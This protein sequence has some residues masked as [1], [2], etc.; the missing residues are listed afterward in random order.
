[1][2]T[3]QATGI[4]SITNIDHKDSLYSVKV[5]VGNPPQF[6]DL[7]IDTGH[8]DWWIYSKG[9]KD[10]TPN[11]PPQNVSLFDPAKSY[12][13]MKSK[14]LWHFI[15]DDFSYAKGYTGT[16]SYQVGNIEVIGQVIEVITEHNTSSKLSRGFDGIFGL[17][18]AALP[19]YGNSARPQAKS[20]VENMIS[21][22]LLKEPVFAI[23]LNT[24]TD[25]LLTLGYYD[26]SQIDGPMVKVPLN[27]EWSEK[28]LW[29]VDSK[30]VS[31]NGVPFTRQAN[32]VMLIDSGCALNYVSK[33]LVEAIYAKVPGATFDAAKGGWVYPYANK[34]L[35]TTVTFHIGDAEFQVPH[36]ALC[37][38]GDTENPKDCYGSIQ[39]RGTLPYDIIGDPL[40]RYYLVA[41]Y[42]ESKE[43][44]IA[45]R[46]G[47]NYDPK[48]NHAGTSKVGVSA[49][50]GHAKGHSHAR[51]SGTT[52]PAK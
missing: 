8:T 1:M 14:N 30:T 9:M 15:Y 25:G 10:L 16:D 28:G 39:D 47:F 18:L 23:Q 48:S 5:S 19:P 11:A 2:L 35:I 33:D 22:G 17:G 50:G 6:F 44:G 13:F 42:P 43:V 38:T 46:K 12:S 4:A 49:A 29:M 45:A 24:H 32:T 27:K 51:K 26:A 31:I 7:S 40:Y 3:T 36:H 20:P 37:Y 41:H 21:R 34:D 52:A